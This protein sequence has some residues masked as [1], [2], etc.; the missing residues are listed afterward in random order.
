MFGALFHASSFNKTCFIDS[1][2]PEERSVMAISLLLAARS[3]FFCKAFCPDWASQTQRALIQGA[4]N[5][6]VCHKDIRSGA[7]FR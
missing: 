1:C 4:I 7:K 5:L 6:T 3:E 2:A